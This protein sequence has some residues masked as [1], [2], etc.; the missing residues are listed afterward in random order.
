[1]N[2]LKY[3]TLVAIIT[4]GLFIIGCNKAD[5]SNAAA[6]NTNTT[7]ANTNAHSTGNTGL[8]AN[9]AKTDST[10]TGS[11]AT[12]TDAYKFAYDCRK[13]KDVECLKK[14]M[15]KDIIEFFTLIGKDDKKSADDMIKE[16][17][18][19][20]QAPTCESRKEKIDGDFATIEYLNEKGE[21]KTM[22]FEKVG[23]D[24]KMGAPRKPDGP[25]K[26]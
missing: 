15:T 6:N 22:D 23:S 11:M 16:L 14:V 24:W 9:E 3:L 19:V 2:K 4:I 13:R 17:I 5:N 7:A 26:K 8:A 10:S 1:M 18:E 21:W 25:P 12:P 20:P